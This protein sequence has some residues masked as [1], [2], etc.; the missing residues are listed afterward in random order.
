MRIN[1]L[2][3]IGFYLLL[4]LIV[5]VSIAPF[6]WQFVSSISL[7]RDLLQRPPQW[8]PKQP[9]FFRYAALLGLTEDATASRLDI[10]LANAARNFRSGTFNSLVVASTTTLISLVLGTLGAY[11]V[12]RLKFPGRKAI[13]LLVV[14]VRMIPP[15]S[16]I[17]PLYIFIGALGLMNTKAALILTYTSFMLPL[18]IW[19]M[20]AFFQTVPWD[21]E[22]A[23]LIDGCTPLSALVRVILPLAAP[24]L[25]AAA[26][27]A[28]LYA[29]NE[30]FFALIFTNTMQSK[31]ITKVISEFSTEM[32]A[33]L[34]YGLVTTGGVLTCL[35][36]IAI[37]LFSQRF[38]I[39]GLTGGS[40]KS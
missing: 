23:A 24:G 10:A 7:D 16:I 2:K 17:I 37:A 3:R 33:G 11:A 40:V 14:S 29:W 39:Q 21:I 26:I 4:A 1:T 6:Y 27:V 5:F 32:G 18:V 25:A 31:T 28:F 13:F 30:F 20:S 15:I 38:L 35:P 22:E 19:I 34:D 12:T 36:P 9:V 8:V